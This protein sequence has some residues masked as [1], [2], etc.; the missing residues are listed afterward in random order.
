MMSSF[1]SLID[2]ATRKFS[3]KCPAIDY[4]NFLIVLPS[5][6]KLLYISG[7]KIVKKYPISTS[8]FG[9]GNVE[10]SFKTPIG[11]HHIEEKIGKGMPINT[12]FKGRKPIKNNMTLE[13][14]YNDEKLRKDHFDNYDDVITTRILRLKGL[15]KN[16]N[17]G[18]NVDSYLR[19]IYIHG[20]A[21]EDQI[22]REASHGCIRMLNKDIIELFDSCYEKMLVL[23]LDN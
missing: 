8:K 19:Y 22:G 4:A 2:Q 16:I 18:G 3:T 6:Q 15:E 9:L 5:N 23:I 20:T 12:V 17:L 14:L 7:H 13:D 1:D 10:D 11:I 21:H